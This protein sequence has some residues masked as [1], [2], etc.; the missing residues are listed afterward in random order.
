MDIESA[1]RYELTQEPS[2]SFIDS[3]VYLL[4]RADSTKYLYEHLDS[5]SLSPQILNLR[6]AIRKSQDRDLSPAS[7]KDLD[8]PLDRMNGTD[9]AGQDPAKV[10]SNVMK[11]IEY[12][13]ETADFRNEGLADR[14]EIEAALASFLD[15]TP[16][17]ADRELASLVKYLYLDLIPT[18]GGKTSLSLEEQFAKV[19]EKREVIQADFQLT[20]KFTKTKLFLLRE[21]NKKFLLHFDGDFS[22]EFDQI[23]DS[24][25]K[26]Q[27]QKLLELN[28]AES[29][30]KLT[31]RYDQMTID[32]R[33]ERFDLI[34]QVST[35]LCEIKTNFILDTKTFDIRWVSVVRKAIAIYNFKFKTI[36]H[37]ELAN[38][39]TKY[40]A[41]YPCCSVKQ[42]L[43]S[44]LEGSQRGQTV[45]GIEDSDFDYIAVYFDP[46]RG[47]YKYIT[48]NDSFVKAESSITIFND[49]TESINAPGTVRILLSSFYRQ[50]VPSTD[51]VTF[52]FADGKGDKTLKHLIE[53][54]GETIDPDI[55]PTADFNSHLWFALNVDFKTEADLKAAETASRA[56]GFSYD[57]PV[58]EVVKAFWK[59]KSR[60]EEQEQFIDLVCFKTKFTLEDPNNGVQMKHSQHHMTDLVITRLLT[61]ESLFTYLFRIGDERHIKTSGEDEPN[62]FKNYDVTF[63]LPNQL[64]VDVR[65]VTTKIEHAQDMELA[66]L[67]DCVIGDSKEM[68]ECEYKVKGGIMRTTVTASPG[69]SLQVFRPFLVEHHKNRPATFKM[70]TQKSPEGVP[71]N[72]DALNTDI[73]FLFYERKT[74][75]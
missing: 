72:I 75:H 3:F 24:A 8:F 36:S 6:E 55:K 30:S 51:K 53:F 31:P 47:M 56:L 15:S 54:A 73:Y 14:P 61:I 2:H 45:H 11:Y 39:M 63:F 65:T 17:F 5:D 60:L 52:L 38:S 67:R 28:P 16:N 27:L 4:L 21:M 29:L 34:N 26:R 23:I 49:S 7:L 35:G 1:F 71:F 70:I 46:K 50:T 44:Y 9:K 58:S 59:G 41:H 40:K 48:E 20:T 32:H 74:A 33:F 10:L 25:H 22:K 42:M 62:K 66:F 64:F 13:F 69:S 43:T 18:P 57:T 68:V 19:Y 12:Y 37:C